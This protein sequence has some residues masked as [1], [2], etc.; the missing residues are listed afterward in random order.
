MASTGARLRSGK[1]HMHQCVLSPF[2]VPPSLPPLCPLV[3]PQES[4]PSWLSCVR[5]VHPN[6]LWPKHTVAQ[7][8]KNRYTRCIYCSVRPKNLE[9]EPLGSSPFSEFR[10]VFSNHLT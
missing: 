9:L 4:D 5:L 1:G 6:Q 7:D 10:P 2:V 3:R 8:T